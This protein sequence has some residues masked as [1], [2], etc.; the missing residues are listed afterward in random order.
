MDHHRAAR[1]SSRLSFFG[2]A[3]SLAA[4]TGEPVHDAPPYVSRAV[5]QW[6]G[7]TGE[8]GGQQTAETMRELRKLRNSRAVLLDQAKLYEVVDHVERA[9]HAAYELDNDNETSAAECSASGSPVCASSLRRPGNFHGVKAHAHF[10]TEILKVHPA[11][12][13]EQVQSIVASEWYHP[14]LTARAV[15]CTS[16][17][18]EQFPLARRLD[19]NAEA[20]RAEV[21]AFWS[22]PDAAAELKGVGAHT[23]QFDKMIAG[24]GTWVDVRLWRGRAFNRRLCE[25]HFR[26]VCR[27]VEASPEVWTS[28][29]SH[30]L[31]SIL[32]P[33]SW[34]PFH[35]GHSN[36][37]LTYHFPVMMPKN[38]E[39]TELAV[40]ERGGSL[41]ESESGKKKKELLSHPEER[42]VQWHLG[43]TLVFDDSFTHAVRFRQSE[44]KP[45]QR[46]EA[47]VLLLL[48]GW[49]PELEPEE[50][51]AIRE[52]VRRGGE[53]DP[54]GYEMLPIPPSVFGAEPHAPGVMSY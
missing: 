11:F 36:G 23:T 46:E 6:L 28:P 8:Q 21:T 35:Q 12:T 42:T 3:I 48:R 54:E 17:C 44:E 7:N 16:N 14:G 33:G 1:A 53:E 9:M 39:L 20:I 22:H 49:H 41:A 30:V 51:V 19:E 13:F 47:R 25:K 34:V 43:K 15:W 2:V 10:V 4:T 31:L 45:T 52:L 37:Q 24:N 29:W 40:V 50:R 5:E 18:G 27:L 38:E 32:L 26:T